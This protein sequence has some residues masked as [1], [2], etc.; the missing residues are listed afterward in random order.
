MGNLKAAFQKAGIKYAYQ[1]Y[2]ALDKYFKVRNS[3]VWQIATE[4]SLVDLA[5]LLPHM[6]YPGLPQADALYIE[7]DV[8]YHF[9]CDV[10]LQKPE[11]AA[12]SILNLL[13]FPESGSFRDPYS[14]YYDLRKKELYE[15]VLSNNPMESLMEA[16]KL[17]SCYDFFVDADAYKSV[18]FAYLPNIDEQREFLS[19]L[20]MSQFP[21]KGLTFLQKTGF[22]KAAWPELDR[23]RNI[24]QTK[25]YHPEG[26]VWQHTLNTF[27]FRKRCDLLLS[28]SLL[29]HDI[30]K[31]VT[32]GTA[33]RPFPEHSEK[34]AY[35]A[36]KFLQR[37]KF[38]QLLID[39]TAFLI[40]FHMLPHALNRL[41]LYRTEKLMTSP[42][43][44][45]LLEIYRADSSSS[46]T[47][48]EGYYEA[49]RVYQKF[50]KTKGKN[51]E[52]KKFQSKYLS[53]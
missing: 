8:V 53:D 12:F 50:M 31:A 5:T 48:P 10:N 43:F 17:I 32:S 19:A 33:N 35:E 26:D 51:A 47:G 1:R 29:L 38:P 25:D 36:R 13:Y 20:M 21:E 39:N 4:G 27:A 2:S 11:R 34:G 14:V 6:E 37:L 22:L 44:P 24:K 23:M 16:A 18:N 49:C 3:K 15:D 9:K 28:L 46:F 7:D 42:L 30:G 45:I 40:R 41:P 52:F